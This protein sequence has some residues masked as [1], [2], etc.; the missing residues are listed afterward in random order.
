MNFTREPIIETIITPKEGYK[1]SLRRT[2]T[3][4]QEEFVVDAVEVVSFGHSHFFR[5]LE[6]P[7][8]FLL[9]VSDYE[10][11][12]TKETRMVLK[13]ATV[14]KSIKIGGGK[15]ET[16]QDEESNKPKKRRT[17]RRRSQKEEETSQVTAEEPK[18]QTPPPAPKKL[19]PPP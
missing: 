14:E 17:R 12:E 19:L 15:K 6:R 11:I 7:K 2:S 5:S 13:K 3:E 9:P 10:V 4:T 18:A 16:Q 8:S 1:L